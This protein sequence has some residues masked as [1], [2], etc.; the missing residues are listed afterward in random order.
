MQDFLCLSGIIGNRVNALSKS[1]AFGERAGS[2]VAVSFQQNIHKALLVDSHGNRFA[3]RRIAHDPVAGVLFVEVHHAPEAATGLDTAKL[4][5]VVFKER[6]AGIRHSIC[7]VDLAGLES[8][9]Q[10]VAVRDGADG[11]FVNFDVAVPVFC[12]LHQFYMII[13]YDLCSHKR[14][15][16]HNAS[17]LGK[18]GF[19]IDDTAVALREIVHQNRIWLR[20]DDGQLLA[21][22]LYGSDL[23]VPGRPLMDLDQML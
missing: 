20:C 6:I 1:K 17:V 5:F 15:G 16:A 18:T 4:E 19:H 14:T 7:R 8:H 2:G 9:R 3:D 10:R 13:C 23:Q 22:R 12:I 11:D 21:V